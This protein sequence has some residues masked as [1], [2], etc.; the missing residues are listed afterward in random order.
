MR[1]VSVRLSG[2]VMA[3]SVMLWVLS[4]CTQQPGVTIVIG[5]TPIPGGDATH[6]QDISVSNSFF[7]LSFA[8][9]SEPPWGVAPG[10]LVDIGLRKAGELQSDFV[11][12]VD[13]LPNGWQA[14][15]TLV[16]AP[17]VTRVSTDEVRVV[18]RRAWQGAQFLT[19]FT[20]YADLDRIAIETT[21]HNPT[22]TAIQDLSSGYALWPDGGHLYGLSGFE[23]VETSVRAAGESMWS[24][25]YDEHWLLALYADFDDHFLNFARDRLRHHTLQPGESRQF[26]ALLQIG[27]DGDLTPVMATL[28]AD[29][30][31]GSARLSGYIEAGDRSKPA[32]GVIMIESVTSAG[33]EPFAWARARDGVFAFQLPAGHYKL[34]ASAPHHGDSTAQDIVLSAGEQRE[35]A[36][37]DLAPPAELTLRVME[38][39]TQQPLDARVMIVEGPKPAIGFFG[40]SVWFTELHDQGNLTL[41]LAPGNYTLEISS[42]G[43]FTS[44]P[45]QVVLSLAG[46][47]SEDLT[48]LI[49][50]L[51]D[52][53]HR[54]WFT[55][56]L[57]HHSD[58][59][60]GYTPPEFVLRSQLAAGL[61]F[62]FLSDHD[63]T[64]NNH[65]MA[66]LSAERALPFIA[67]TEL[68]PSWAHFNAY[69][70]NT[71]AVVSVPVNRSSAEAL[72][73]E[74]RRMGADVV[75]INHPFIDYGYFRSH[76]AGGVPGGFS[77]GFDVVEIS[78][79][80]PNEQTIPAVWAMWNAGQRKYF[81][82]G[83]DAHD[84]W[85]E[86]SGA[87]RTFAQIES[88]PS[89]TAFIEAVRLGH[90]YAS[91]G[92][93]IFPVSPFGSELNFEEGEAI[94]LTFDLVAVA[95]LARASLIEQGE[96]VDTLELG[97]VRALQDLSFTVQ[98]EDATWFSL[99]VEDL[100]GNQA[101]SNPWWLLPNGL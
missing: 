5:P 80:Y 101:V 45:Q 87:V 56:D 25:F 72:F 97:G 76:E 29:A 83:S 38:A 31:E 66:A 98:P 12:L 22:N 79:T 28:A 19:E 16:S 14:G 59:L 39:D 26:N 95:G 50:E 1:G 46:G 81:S 75:Q 74:A 9:G 99:V 30:A 64:V 20:V 4:G 67:G 51:L 8:A 57:H 33:P 17:E 78:S 73:A 32:D 53:N 37:V 77:E 11:S 69:P 88:P 55:A 61:D 96:T 6:A 2:P 63:A 36:F 62:S 52:P 92:P 82:A 71:D 10:G 70:V 91:A 58:V 42:G 3:L 89:V 21:L 48:V 41:S 84:V 35:L 47:H 23:G 7:T 40:Q 43:G 86:I 94:A 93:M 13:F 27:A 65:A 15:S 34:V 44:A 68:S 49:D 54:G 24:A 100:Q 90:S 18:T 85:Q 60:D